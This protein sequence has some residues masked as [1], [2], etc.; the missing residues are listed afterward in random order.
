MHNPA[1]LKVG[2]SKKCFSS[3]GVKREYAR[4]QFRPTRRFGGV[5]LL[6]DEYV[7]SP[8]GNS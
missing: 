5:I 1:G 7:A 3:K 8:N 6:D 4:P 2:E